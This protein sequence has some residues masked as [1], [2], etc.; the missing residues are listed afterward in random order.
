MTSLK[1]EIDNIIKKYKLN[2]FNK[3]KVY[4]L[5]KKI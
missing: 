1:E 5:N 2:I 4:S 3:E